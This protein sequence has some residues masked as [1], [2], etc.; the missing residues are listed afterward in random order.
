MK[1]TATIYLFIMLALSHY[2]C[3]QPVADPNSIQLSGVSIEGPLD[4]VRVALQEAGFTEWGQSDDGED[5]YFRGNYY[6]FRAKLMVSIAKETTF[7]TSAYVTIGPYS[8]E[9]MLEKNRLYFLYKLK[10][11]YDEFTERD[12][13]WFYIDDWGSIKLSVNQ[14]ENGSREIGILYLP[15]APYYKDGLSMGLR[16]AIQEV[17]TENAVAEEQFLH[18]SGHGQLENPDLAE[19]HYNRYGYLLSAQMK[20]REGSSQVTYDYDENYRLIRRTLVNS[21][22][23][24]TYINDYTYNPE[25]EILTQQQKV[26]NSN[27]ECIMTINMRNSYMT[28]DDTGNWTSNSL[29]LTYWEK[30]GKTQQVTVL[31]KRT[32]TYWE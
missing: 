2:V 21:T 19:R 3:A 1:K 11:D 12:N 29:N 28:R 4:S 31:Q 30:G 8:T 5:F 17:V 9:K 14:N 7:V 27:Q 26:Y 18:F 13:S 10:Q 32:M 22:A 6:G 23:G 15:T 25:G 24:I 16:G 20:E